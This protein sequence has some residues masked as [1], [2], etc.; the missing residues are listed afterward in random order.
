MANAI[1]EVAGCDIVPASTP[2]PG[3]GERV[4]PSKSGEYRLSESGLYR[5]RFL[6]PGGIVIGQTPGLSL[7][8]VTAIAR[9]YDEATELDARAHR[10]AVGNR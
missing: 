7:R 4:H 5:V 8:Q 1:P 2:V 10:A 6:A 3:A 9:G